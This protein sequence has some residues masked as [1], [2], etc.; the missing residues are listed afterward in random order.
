MYLSD[1]L[2]GEEGDG[3][4]G[5]LCLATHNNMDQELPKTWCHESHNLSS[6]DV[7]QTDSEFHWRVGRGHLSSRHPVAKAVTGVGGPAPSPAGLAPSGRPLPI[8]AAHQYP[9]HAR[10]P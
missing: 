10:R 5:P 7:P 9:G 3:V 8:V 1:A 6:C 2:R 4:R